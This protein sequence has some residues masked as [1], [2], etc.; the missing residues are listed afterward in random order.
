MKFI[1]LLSLLL[2]QAAKAAPKV[3]ALI[4]EYSY[5]LDMYC[6]QQVVPESLN[7]WEL[8]LIPKIPTYRD[9]ELLGK[10]S[11]F[12]AEW[13]KQG[14]SLLIAAANEVKKPFPMVELTAALFLCPRYPLIARQVLDFKI[15]HS[16]YP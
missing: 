9:Q 4:L 8:A 7:E 14:T 16:L 10:I 13:N 5:A 1:F 2:V 11:W 3:P 12:Q 6:P 15:S